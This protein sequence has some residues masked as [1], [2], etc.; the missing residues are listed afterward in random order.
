MHEATERNLT[1]ERSKTS[2]AVKRRTRRHQMR[3]VLLVL[4]Y[5]IETTG[6]VFM[7]LILFIGENKFHYSLFYQRI[8]F[9]FG[10]FLYAVPIPI[11]YLLNETRVRDVIVKHGWKEGFKA[12]FYSA[13]KI[14]NFERKKSY[15][16]RR[17]GNNRININTANVDGFNG[18]LERFQIQAM[19]HGQPTSSANSERARH[20]VESQD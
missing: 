11:S 18:V 5:A 12:I 10:T 8:L 4:D 1:S 17:P 19:L 14:R 2:K 20:N 3:K 15:I 6:G 13:D 9:C 16:G 7:F